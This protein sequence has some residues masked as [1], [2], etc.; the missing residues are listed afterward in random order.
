VPACAPQSP[1][2][3]G[4]ARPFYFQ[5]K[6]HQGACGKTRPV[7]HNCQSKPES[8]E[9]GGYEMRVLLSTYRSRGDVE[10]LM[11]IGAWR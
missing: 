4:L 11:P 7:L 2:R 1:F 9:M 8:T 3:K 6:A 5:Y 10:P